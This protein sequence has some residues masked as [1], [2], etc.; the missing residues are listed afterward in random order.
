MHIKPWT[1]IVSD[2]QHDLMMFF[3]QY[4][5]KNTNS[6]VNH[7]PQNLHNAIEILSIT[8]LSLKAPQAF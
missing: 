7:Y 1:Y 2:M 6:T 5:K 4:M 8:S 3:L